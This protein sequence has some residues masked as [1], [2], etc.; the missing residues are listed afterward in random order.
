MGFIAL[1]DR[2]VLPA[3]GDRT[4][5]VS[6]LDQI[7]D[8][9]AAC[10]H[11]AGHAILAYEVGWWVNFEGLE[12]DGQEYTGLGCREIDFT[13]WRRIWVH[14]AGLM[15]ESKLLQREPFRGR[16]GLYHILSDVK[17]GRNVTGDAGEVLRAILVQF[18]NSTDQELINAY[19][20]YERELWKEI[21]DNQALWQRIDCVAKALYEKNKL[22]AD[23]V[24]DLL[25]SF[26]AT[27]TPNSHM[28]TTSL[29]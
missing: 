14:L 22:T 6:I 9:W 19:Q 16:D 4:S 3:E 29:H 25:L 18:P 27:P 15:A 5:N 7:T 21:N 20:E 10:Y 11:E 8:H 1:E 2:S 23:E 13:P 12:V 17:T 28:S 24:E 26:R